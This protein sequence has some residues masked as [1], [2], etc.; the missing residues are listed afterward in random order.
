[1]LLAIAALFVL[2]GV[3]LLL[4]EL[5]LTR[6]FGGQSLYPT[7]PANQ[8]KTKAALRRAQNIELEKVQGVVQWEQSNHK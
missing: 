5:F 2:P 1:M 6:L 8:A 3:L 4:S 7:V